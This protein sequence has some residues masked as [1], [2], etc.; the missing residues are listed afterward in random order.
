MKNLS[1]RALSALLVLAL[2]V[3]LAV[4]A[5]AAETVPVT[6][7]GLNKTEV[8][9]GIGE[10]VTL[11]PRITP[12]DATNQKVT[13]KS[14][15][16]SVAS[17]T[18]DG[19]VTAKAAGAA[20]ITV[21]TSDGG[22]LAVC[23]VTV[24]DNYVTDLTLTPGGPETLPAG[25]TR[26]LKAQVDFAHEPS[27]S[28]E[29]TW[30]SNAPDVAS[31]SP[32]GLVS[33]LAPGEAE[34]M[35][36]T[37]ENGRN[38][39]PIFKVYKLTVS[40]GETGDNSGDQLFLDKTAVSQ[41]GGLNQTIILNAPEAMVLRGESE[42]T[43]DYTLSWS[44]TNGEGSVISTAQTA[45]LSL[46]SRE[47]STVTCAV[48]ARSR[49]DSTREPLTGTCVYTVQVLPGTVVEAALDVSSGATRLD[50]LMNQ[51]KTLS[52]IDQ[53]TRGGETQFTPA[54][55]GL[56]DVVFYPDD[57]AGEAGA[58]NVADG[59]RYSVTA[60]AAEKLADVVFVPLAEGTYII[61]FTAYGEQAYFGQLE[62]T[63]TCE[64]D[65]VIT[66]EADMVCDS[67]GLTFAGSDFF[68][69]TDSDPV[70]SLSF[71]KPSAGQLLRDMSCGSGAPDA[72]ARYYTDSARDGDYHVSTLS[73]LPP[74]GF[75]G[76]VSIP[77]RCT[78]RS[79]QVADGFLVVEVRHKTASDTFSDVTPDGAGAWAADS[80]DFAYQCGL[81]NGMEDDQFAPGATMNRAM[82]VTVLYRAAGSPEMTVTT[83]FTDLNAN[84]YYYNAVVWAN[85]MGVVDGTSETTFSP[86]D[87]VTRQQ[88]AVILYRYAALSGRADGTD[89][90]GLDH[91][92]D[93]AQVGD[94]ALRAMGWA[95]AKGIIT[96]T[97]ENT[98]SPNDPA[99]RAQVVVMLHRYLAV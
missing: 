43:A 18:S 39:T 24:E 42:V 48:T 33:A 93:R 51:D 91:F 19:V 78:S 66:G 6:G 63:V 64:V 31:V 37:R 52:V 60:E 87:P 81:V 70:A 10:T 77:L 72:G 95:V 84:S 23:S 94:Y 4:P 34:I 89:V 29:V 2:A 76:K 67:S 22:Y 56:T 17:V 47:E 98:L 8:V 59:E 12:S 15:K 38:G 79:G 1:R 55:P 30:S 26:Q 65:P 21:T 86:D 11:V 7:V 28:Q 57:A 5:L 13:W 80:V 97:D 40:D 58:L 62:V 45:S 16:T 35:A 44:W 73:Y 88:I 69:S 50:K 54:I 9:L 83:N 68:S 96:G 3:T 36:M 61:P 53:L 14:N 85:A 92:A 46:A 20:N 27:G 75:A 25:K 41:Q 32:Q 90:A 82:L 74:A 71:S 49:T 99:T